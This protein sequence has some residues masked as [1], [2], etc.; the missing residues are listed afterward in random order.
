[1]KNSQGNRLKK[2]FPFLIS[3]FV[4]SISYGQDNLQNQQLS[5]KEILIGIE[6]KF[7]V[8]FSYLDRDIEGVK[9]LPPAP[10]LDLEETLQKLRTT[11]N[12]SF[13]KIDERYIA[14]NKENTEVCGIL[15]DSNTKEPLSGATVL[16]QDSGTTTGEAG[17]FR[18]NSLPAGAVI[19]IS[20]LG[21]GSLSLPASYFTSGDCR[22]IYMEAVA[23]D[24]QEALVVNYLTSGISKIKDGAVKIDTER[25][26]VLPGLLEPD[27]LQ[28]LEA[29]PGVESV[30]ETISNLN[31]RGGTSDQNLVLFDGIKMYLTGHFFGLISA[32]NSNLTREAYLIKN[33]SAASLHEGVSGTIDIRSQD[34]H[35]ENFSAGAGA[36]LV[37]A[38]AYMKIPISQKL[39]V[40]VSGRRSL[41]DVLNTP[42]YNSYFD[43]TFQD[44][45]IPIPGREDENSNRIADFNYYDFSFKTLYDHNERHKFRLSSLYIDNYLDYTEFTAGET[46]R[47]E[48][49]SSLAQRNLATGGAWNAQ[50]KE[51]F[52]TRA[53]AYLTRYGLEATNLSLEPEQRLVQQNEVL[54]TGITLSATKDIT[55]FLSLTTGYHF[56]EVGVLNAENVSNPLFSSRIKNVIRSHAAFS[57]LQYNRGRIFLR[58]GFRANYFDK[59]DMFIPEPRLSFN[60][61]INS[62]INFKALGEF[63]S[64]VTS[65]S[66]DLQEDFLG[67][68]NRRWI[69]ANNENFP[70]IRSRQASAGLDFRSGGWYIDMEAYYKEVEGISTSNQGFQDQNEF[71]RVAGSYIAK[72][73]ELLVNKK[74]RNFHTYFS[75][76]L[77]SSQYR[78]EELEP[79]EFPNNFDIP[80]SASLAVNYTYNRLKFSVGGKWRSGRPFT[81]PVAG[82]ETR[83]EGNRTVVNFN[84]PN[85]NRLPHFFRLDASS[86]YTFFLAEKVRAQFNLGFL[87]LLNRENVINSY[88]KVNTEDDSKAVRID[89]TSLRF[90][91]NALFRVEF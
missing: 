77:A 80:H 71:R 73:V 38:D 15:I 32:F 57:E 24:L 86:S 7:E 44:T 46:S 75:Y 59:F 4:L 17:Q 43:R 5:L 27:V 88:Y 34:E 55:E 68:E 18:I 1:M 74:F 25:F 84:D 36:S 90:T 2:I 40:H 42:A 62:R 49:K 6:Q 52:S 76:T 50:W 56:F 28:T 16:T 79:Q 66:I 83:R 41:N 70:V 72:G 21:Y 69:L 13:Q 14:V 23:Q 91:P 64:Q 87:N 39:E 53:L 58:T 31:I 37:S 30:N 20:Y 85:S 47:A 60:Y 67:V 12:L 19:N 78:F 63:K 29:L 81:T 8:R 89:N 22:E 54:E 10:S 35:E 11:T 26:G 33:G 9:M 82:N 65:Q 45:G 51:G 61:R 3:L 48:R